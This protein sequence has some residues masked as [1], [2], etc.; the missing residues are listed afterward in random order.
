ME[1]HPQW[2]LSLAGLLESLPKEKACHIPVTYSYPNLQMQRWDIFMTNEFS[3]FCCCV[4]YWI[5][6]FSVHVFF[7]FFLILPF[8]MWAK[9]MHLTPCN[10][11]FLP[12]TAQWIP[13]TLAWHS[14][15][16]LIWFHSF[17]LHSFICSC[18]LFI[19]LNLYLLSL[20][21]AQDTMIGIEFY[22]RICR[23]R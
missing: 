5:S 3:D 21:Y 16:S 19:S 7:F 23:R 10:C 8:N 4:S 15:S 11:T 18:I 9:Y 20:Y 17:L 13:M 1:D 22:Q 2:F 6:F 12:T 14:R